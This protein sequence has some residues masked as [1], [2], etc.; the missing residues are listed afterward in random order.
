MPRYTEVY[1]LAMPAATSLP[2][3]PILKLLSNQLSLMF[4]RLPIVLG[5]I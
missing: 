1:A 5:R 4:A 2:V 3:L